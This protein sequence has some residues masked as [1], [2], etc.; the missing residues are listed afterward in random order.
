MNIAMWSGP[1]NLSTA[2]MY[3]FAQR[4]DMSVRDEPFYAAYLAATGLAHPLRAAVLASQPTDPAEVSRACARPAADGRPAYLKLMTH[5]MLPGFDT[6]F[7]AACRNVFLIRHPARVL[8]S[9]AARRD[10][11]T[12]AD[13]GIVRQRALFEAA[14]ARG[15]APVVIDSADIRADSD[16]MLRALCAALGLPF[17]PAMLSWPAG[18]NAADG[19]WAPHWYGAVHRST[20][21]AGPE[22]APPDLPPHLAE[23]CDAALPDYAALARHRLRR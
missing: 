19:A 20:G 6:G 2:L 3:A 1:R 8:A 21:F 17:D 9:Y 13:I 5:H 22:G 16:A 10:T 4:A 18:G 12:L 7:M 15:D 23:L 14:R 11:A